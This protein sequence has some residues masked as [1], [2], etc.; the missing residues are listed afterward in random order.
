MEVYVPQASSPTRGEQMWLAGSL[1]NRQVVNAST[2]EPVGRVHD[3]VFDPMTCR[4]VALKIQPAILP[5]TGPIAGIRRAFGASRS[6]GYVGLEHILSLNGDVV[7][8]DAAPGRSISQYVV[9]R[10][11]HLCEVCEL[12]II[13]LHGI[14]LGSLADVLMDAKGSSLVG[15][16][17]NPAKQ[18]ED[19]MMSLDSVGSMARL[20]STVMA[21]ASSGDAPYATDDSAEVATSPSHLC[22]IPASPRVR[23]GD[24]LIL[25]VEEIEPLQKEAVIVTTHVESIGSVDV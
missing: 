21:D 2:L 18:A 7:I 25:V 15:Y 16:V 10:M 9:G 3:V 22:F 5:E 17:V 6:G 8:V 14:C 19:L 23:I 1:V 12:A 20:Q 4:L 13:T 24:A 11:P